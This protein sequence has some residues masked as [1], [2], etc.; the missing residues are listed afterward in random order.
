MRLAVG[1]TCSD[2]HIASPKTPVTLLS[3]RLPAIVPTCHP[4]FSKT[5]LAQFFWK[6]LAD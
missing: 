5:G 2:E 4:N 6:I 1:C 3:F